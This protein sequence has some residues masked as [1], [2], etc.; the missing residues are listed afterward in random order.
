MDL[1]DFENGPNRKSID[2]RYEAWTN[3]IGSDKRWIN[4]GYVEKGGVDDR[5]E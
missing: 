2:D 4:D 1:R 3:T 5:W